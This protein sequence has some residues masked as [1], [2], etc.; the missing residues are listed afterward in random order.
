[1]P[2]KLKRWHVGLRQGVLLL[3]LGFILGAG[4]NALRANGLPWF[5]TWTP[6][7]A[8]GQNIRDLQV[9][10]IE[11]AWAL[12][13]GGMALFLDARD[14]LTFQEGHI[15][16]AL[17]VPPQE[18]DAYVDE[19]RALTASGMEVI[20][21]CDGADCPLG[22]ELA[23]ALRSRGIPSVKILVD[24]WSA[25]LKAGHPVEQDHGR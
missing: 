6:V 3:A 8:A 19:L 10:S 1:M 12:Y 25:W 7:D 15:A 11:E 4:F 13:Q 23:M 20:S 9:L 18:V 2:G 21:Y 14:H 16:G 5:Q 22:P 17:N 24:G